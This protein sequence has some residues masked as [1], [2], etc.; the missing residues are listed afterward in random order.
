MDKKAIIKIFIILVVATALSLILITNLDPD[1]IVSLQTFEIL[2]F[3]VVVP[4]LTTILYV[5]FAQKFDEFNRKLMLIEG[6]LEVLVEQLHVEEKDLMA[7]E[8][9]LRKEIK[10]LRKILDRMERDI[11]ILRKQ[12]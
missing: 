5:I 11:K 12:K 2:E 10:E 7:E 8:V 3:L 4:V 1:K 9:I 6:D